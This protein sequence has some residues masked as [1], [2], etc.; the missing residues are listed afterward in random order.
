MCDYTKSQTQKWIFD[1]LTIFN[2]KL[3]LNIMKTIFQSRY[4][5]RISVSLIVVPLFRAV[6]ILVL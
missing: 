2:P 4:K 1:K 3:M 6:Y 5:F